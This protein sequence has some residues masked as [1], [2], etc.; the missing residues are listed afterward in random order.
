MLCTV[1]HFRSR[2]SNQII[3]LFSGFGNTFFG[4]IVKGESTFDQRLSQW[5]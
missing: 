2:F 5:S 4:G 1:S 3:E